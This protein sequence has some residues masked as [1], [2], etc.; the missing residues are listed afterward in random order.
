MSE[1]LARALLTAAALG[2]VLGVAYLGRRRERRAA[3]I[4]QLRLDGVQGRMLF[5]TDAACKRCD[6]VRDRLE[7]LGATFVEIAYNHEPDL[8]RAIGV[9][10]VPLLIVRDGAGTIVDRI[11]GAASVRRIR[12]A[13]SQAG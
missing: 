8:Q 2:V 9:T 6:L 5:F 4:T 13:L 12:R 1:T 10:G 3:A 7:S 11:A